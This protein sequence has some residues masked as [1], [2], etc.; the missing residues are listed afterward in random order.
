MDIHGKKNHEK[1][2]LDAK[3]RRG[4]DRPAVT[5]RG[6]EPRLSRPR[7]RAR[8]ASAGAC[9]RP[10]PHDSRRVGVPLPS[11]KGGGIRVLQGV[12]SRR[13]RPSVASRGRF[14]PDEGRPTRPPV[15]LGPSG[16]DVF[17]V[18]EQSVFSRLRVRWTG[19]E[20]VTPRL[21]TWCS[22]SELPRPGPAPVPNP[23]TEH[24]PPTVRRRGQA[25]RG[26]DEASRLCEPWYLAHAITRRQ[27]RLACSRG[28]R[29][30]GR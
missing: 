3:R 14:S 23:C 6:A 4:T 10:K 19:V 25:R 1:K 16:R 30:S 8:S 27:A 11:A 22:T 24:T 13:T 26:P 21:K 5:L 18:P 9:M 17:S 20:P 12:R 15:P 29:L 7:R 28:K 2:F